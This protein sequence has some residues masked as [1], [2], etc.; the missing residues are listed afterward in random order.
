MNPLMKSKTQNL[1]LVAK[2]A[3]TGLGHCALGP[4]ERADFYEGLGA[5]LSPPASE[6][7]R[8]LATCIRETQRAEQE[9]LDALETRKGIP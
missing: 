9:L 8:N 7:A 3:V 2:I 1:R 5:I 4:G 6:T